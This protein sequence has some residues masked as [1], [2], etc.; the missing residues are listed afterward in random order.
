LGLLPLQAESQAPIINGSGGK[1]YTFYQNLGDLIRFVDI[2][3]K[4]DLPVSPV[5]EKALNDDEPILF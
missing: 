5:L 2:G 1:I 4:A 3:E